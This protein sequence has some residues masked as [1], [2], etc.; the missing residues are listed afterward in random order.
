MGTS[1][2][3]TAK[4]NSNPSYQIVRYLEDAGL[5]WGILTDGEY[6]RLYSTR[7]QGRFSSYYEVNIRKALNERD[8]ETFKYFFNLFRKEAFLPTAAPDKCF[9]D[10][11]FEE[12]KQYAKEVEVQLK[13][14]VF[15]LIES[16]A[17]GLL[18]DPN[19]P[20]DLNTVYSYSLYY[21]FRL[22]FILNCEAKGLLR[23][24]NLSSYYPF[25]LRKLAIEIRKEFENGISWS[26]SAIKTSNHIGELFRLIQKGDTDIGITGFG[27]DL[28]P[29]EHIRPLLALKVPDSYINE[30]LL[31]LAC[32]YDK[33]GELHFIDYKRLAADHLGSLF[34]GLLEFKLAGNPASPQTVNL[35]NV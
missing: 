5:S 32:A 17:R 14:R 28:F 31:R 2:D 27:E 6:W 33:S 3:G 12:G 30:V 24:D 23:V 34:E 21:L 22:M 9:L 15:T 18:S 13:E 7:A 10:I 20:K 25:S 29:K 1:L 8:D 11:V 4:S 35:E 19:C 16:I 26:K